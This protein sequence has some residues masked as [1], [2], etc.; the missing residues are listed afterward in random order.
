MPVPVIAF[1]DNKVSLQTIFSQSFGTSTPGFHSITLLLPKHPKNTNTDHKFWQQ[2]IVTFLATG[3]TTLTF[4]NGDP[5]SDYSAGL[6]NISVEL[7]PQQTPLPAALPLFATGLI[8][9]GWLARRRRSSATA[10]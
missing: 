4:Y 7:A 3:P 6:D 8:G 1:R 9:L 10:V 5:T 2:F